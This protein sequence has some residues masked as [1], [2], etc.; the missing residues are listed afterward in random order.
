M[1]I[2]G[3]NDMCFLRNLQVG[4]SLFLQFNNSMWVG[5]VSVAEFVPIINFLGMF[6]WLVAIPPWRARLAPTLISLVLAFIRITHLQA[7]LNTNHPGLE[8]KSKTFVGTSFSL[9]T[10]SQQ[11]EQL[12]QYLKVFMCCGKRYLVG[13]VIMMT[14]SWHYYD[15][16]SSWHLPWQ[17][18]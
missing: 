12:S 18:T 14:M 10:V 4:L 8:Q 15:V 7:S 17:L 5:E 11:P 1:T 3:S 13:V 6:W 2:K 16:M 9:S